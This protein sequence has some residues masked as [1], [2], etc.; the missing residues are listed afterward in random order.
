MM[1]A[2]RSRSRFALPE[3]GMDQG[4]GR[5][6]RPSRV[7]DMIRSEI[8]Q[9]LVQKIKDPRV[10]NVTITGVAMTGDLRRARIYFTVFG[11]KRRIKEAEKGLASAKGFI[12]SHLARELGM[13]YVPELDFRLDLA[14]VRREEMERLFREINDGEPRSE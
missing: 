8:S 14:E 11:D 13:R 12:R 6:R 3:L 7:G 1:T 4:Q 9:L 2:K 10:Q 5:S